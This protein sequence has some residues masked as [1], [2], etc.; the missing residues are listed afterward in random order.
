[1]CVCVCRRAEKRGEEGGS[2]EGRE[3]AHT[4]AGV[5]RCTKAR[6]PSAN[7]RGGATHTHAHTGKQRKGG[8]ERDG[9]SMMMSDRL[10]GATTTTL[11]GASHILPF[12]SCL[13]RSPFSTRG[14][15]SILTHLSWVS[16]KG[17]ANPLFPVPHA[18]TCPCCCT[19]TH[20][21]A[22]RYVGS[23]QRGMGNIGFRLAF[24]DARTRAYMH[25]FFYINLSSS[26]LYMPWR[27]QW[28][29]A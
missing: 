26:L 4:K 11:A 19:R 28:N 29:R 14:E 21:H 27:G 12:F 5:Q 18:P 25:I 24:V 23:V 8:G 6:E 2:R 10:R 17:L 1:M 7:E 20:T 16:M 15:P 13:Y 9:G 3:T 22:R